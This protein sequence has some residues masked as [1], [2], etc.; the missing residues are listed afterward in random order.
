MRWPPTSCE[1]KVRGSFWKVRRLCS[2]RKPE[3]AVQAWGY[4]AGSSATPAANLSFGGFGAN[5]QTL[6][7]KHLV[8]LELAAW[9]TSLLEIFLHM[10]NPKKEC[11]NYILSS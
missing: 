4:E 2:C 5:I 1:V 3:H 6:N 10:L 8:L 7:P 9:P 11:V